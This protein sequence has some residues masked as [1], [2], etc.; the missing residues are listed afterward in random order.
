MAAESASAPLVFVSYAREDKELC[1]RLVL[2]LALVL[3]GRG[4]EV[5]WDQVMVAGEWRAQLEEQ[6]E[7]AVAGIVLIS[8]YSLTSRYV[9]EEELTRLLARG[10]VA[11]V[12]CR[13]CPWES[14]PVIASLQF[15]GSTE[16][17]LAELDESRGE[18]A[19]AL[20]ALAK[21]APDFLELLP[22][23]VAGSPVAPSAPDSRAS[24]AVVSERAG[25]L[26]GVPELPGDYFERAVE[27]DRL[28]EM[29]L[30][31]GGGVIG[32]AGLQGAG[33]IGKSVIAA[34]LARD[35]TVRRAFPD[36]VYW[37]VLGE[38]PDT[39]LVQAAL[40][41]AV[42]AD[43]SFRT[44]ED[45]S[46]VLREAFRGQRALIVIDDAWSAADV[47][48]LIV[49][50]PGGRTLITT[51]HALV[52]DRV[53]ADRI[54]VDRLELAEARRFLA[55]MTR[56]GEPLPAEADQLI[57][58]LGGIVLALALIGATIAHGTSWADALA[59]VSAAS[60][61]FADGTFANQ[62]KAM[63][64]AWDA[65]E[66]TTRDRYRELDVFQEDVIIPLVTIGRLWR[67]TAGLDDEET[68]RLCLELA[69]RKLLSTGEGVQFHDLQRAFLELQTADS[70]L[71]HR[72]LLLAHADVPATREQWGTLP[73]DEPYLWDH[74]VEHLIATGDVV[75]L[76]AVLVDPIWL[77]G[78]YRLQG[79]YA[80][81]ADLM[82]GLDA[83]PGYRVGASVLHRFRQISHLLAAVTTPGAQALTFA[84]HMG[85]LIPPE[86]VAELFPPVRLTRR[87]SARAVSDALERVVTGHRGGVWSVAW[88]PSGLQLASGGV[89][90]VVRIWDTDAAG[91]QAAT[92]GGH[93]GAVRSVAWSP[94]GRR[95]ASAADDGTLRIFDSGAWDAPPTVLTGHGAAVWS[96][97]WSPDGARLAS[98]SSDGTVRVWEPGRSAVDL[99]GHHG[100]VWS[101]AW[102]PDGARLASGGAD[103]RVLVWALDESAEPL[104]V[105][106]HDGWVTGVAW[107]PDGGRLATAGDRTVRV[108]DP[109]VPGREIAR[110]SG[111]DDLVWSVA[112]SAD[113]RQVACGTFARTVRVWDVATELAVVLDGHDDRVWSVAWSPDGHR[114]ATGA[115]D[116]TVRV[117]DPAEHV[118]PTSA[119]VAPGRWVWAVAWSPVTEQLATASEDGAVRVW[120]AGGAPLEVAQLDGGAWAVAWSPDGVRL[121]AAGADRIV[122]VWDGLELVALTGHAGLVRDVAFSPDGARLASAS[123][124]GTLRVWSLHGS[125]PPIVVRDEDAMRP[126]CL[127]W[128][129][130]GRRLASGHDDGTLRVRFAD[131]L[132]APPMVFP[133]H[134]GRIESVAWSPDGRLLATAGLDSTVRVRSGDGD[135]V[136]VLTGHDDPVNAVTWSPRGRWLASGSEDGTL[137]LWDVAAGELVSALGVG[138]M[139]CSLAWQGDRLA[140]G[141]ATAWTVFTVE[142]VAA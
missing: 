134:A 89:D 107:S 125:A 140:V 46:A 5:W 95:L 26:H 7:R 130:D 105:G 31:A 72:R 68:E 58:A 60:K 75:G 103:R 98:S 36:G 116:E 70:A 94:D 129:P 102:S 84:H 65:L 85:D 57:E 52:L 29:L 78:R 30:S 121:A 118:A 106:R 40:A 100:T 4:Y 16:K 91:R 122:R 114:L 53:R 110:L 47:E 62:F 136:V 113:G 90:G 6:L 74:L 92:L 21:Q 38:R 35:P 135:E 43:A 55:S 56:R 71:A 120:E 44:V 133:G 51:R 14:D 81:E 76:E 25:G 80:P 117:W 49:T 45:G 142:E 10:R 59:R 108:W 124:D 119:P 82:R 67:H 22:R 37:A 88:S 39:V 12:Y 9:M 66:E 96:V 33:G 2:M 97:A 101:V 19:A 126:R 28:R 131:S 73:E 17:A 112:W 127:T 111:H 3:K 115:D 42:G 63:Q 1:R 41:A 50:G 109:S 141:M 34:A 32:L 15:L 69:E 79:P 8:E 54:A 86:A 137:R 20:S 11:P 23:Q 61:T 87:G 139:I 123:D 27:L 64:V 77:L 104:D 18:L 128:S 48:A 132:G 93:G 138:T 13:P 99:A 83:L 24:A